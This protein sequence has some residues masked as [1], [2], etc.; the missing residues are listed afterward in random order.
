VG[1]KN[2]FGEQQWQTVMASIAPEVKGALEG[3]FGL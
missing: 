2:M 3:R 1:F